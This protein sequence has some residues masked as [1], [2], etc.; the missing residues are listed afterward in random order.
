MLFG[1]YMPWD[2]E[3]VIRELQSV[4]AFFFFL[5]RRRQVRQCKQIFVSVE[6]VLNSQLKQQ[7]CVAFLTL[8]GGI[9]NILF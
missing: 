3:N 2:V 4:E 9:F 7:R 5:G 6:F 8:N 1:R